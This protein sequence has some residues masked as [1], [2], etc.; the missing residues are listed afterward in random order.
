MSNP[1]SYSIVIPIFNSEKIISK[2]Y[3]ELIEFFEVSSLQFEIIFVNDGS[4]DKSSDVLQKIKESDSKVKV[5]EFSKNFGQHN[6]LL[7][8]IRKA[9]NEFIITM[10]DDL[11]HSPDQLHKLIDKINQG[12]DV[13]YGSPKN[14]S[15]SFFRNL[16]SFL[17]KYALQTTIGLQNA[18]KFSAFRIFRSYIV[19]SF[20]D[21]KGSFISI[22]V[23]LTW[24]TNNFSYVDVDFKRRAS[25]KSN[26][27]FKKLLSQAFNML[28]GFSIRPLQLSSL[29]GF[30]FAFFGFSILLYILLNY[31][32]N[33]SS[34][35]GFT[36]LASLISIFSG[37][38]LI[39]IGIIGE[40]LARVH[41]RMMDKPQYII[42]NED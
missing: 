39:T 5:I 42:K 23:L 14:Y 1:A 36:F 21:Y 40:Y 4:A 11:Q 22:D 27:S 29:F 13:V 19:K 20:Y 35:A 37:V 18:R 30:I 15:H 25:G 32:I 24:G 6:A 26:Y 8:G 31:F 33:E 17:T 34:V 16:S 12:Y 9:N 10:D 2:L 3:N 41:F 7:C 38:Q 28:T